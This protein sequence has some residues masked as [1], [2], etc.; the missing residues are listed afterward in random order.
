MYLWQGV[1]GPGKRSWTTDPL[2]WDATEWALVEWMREH[3]RGK[4]E[5][6]F[7]TAEFARLSGS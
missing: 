6:L 3:R 4:G 2:Q 1:A 5:R 7:T